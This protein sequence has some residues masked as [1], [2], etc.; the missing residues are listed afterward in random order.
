MQEKYFWQISNLLEKRKRANVRKTKG[1]C[2]FQPHLYHHWWLSI[3]KMRAASVYEAIQICFV[4]CTIMSCISQISRIV[5]MNKQCEKA[6]I[7]W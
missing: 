7:S 3:Q 6:V 1:Y 5:Q 2:R 4:S